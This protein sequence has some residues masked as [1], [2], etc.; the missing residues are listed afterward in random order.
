MRAAFS[1]SQAVFVDASDRTRRR[2]TVGASPAVAEWS[3]ADRRAEAQVLVGN[4]YLVR[5]VVDG[6]SSADDAV[7]LAE[8]LDLAALAAL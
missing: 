8:R 3:R 4:R 5:L 2:A 7:S 1:V 6:A